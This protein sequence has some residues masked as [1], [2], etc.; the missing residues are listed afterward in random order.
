[1]GTWVLPGEGRAGSDLPKFKFSVAL[2]I[3]L[4][5]ILQLQMKTDLKKSLI[6]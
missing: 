6:S 4:H 1:M 5:V 3:G 2:P